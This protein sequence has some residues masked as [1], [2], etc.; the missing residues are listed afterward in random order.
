MMQPIKRLRQRKQHPDSK[1][2]IARDMTSVDTAGVLALDDGRLAVS[3]TVTIENVV[4]VMEQG[5]ALFDRQDLTIDMAGVTEVDSS[6]VSL[7]LEWQ[8]EALHR[9]HPLL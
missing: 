4:A 8:R 2:L 9:G 6:T 5:I 3:G 1:E 7:L